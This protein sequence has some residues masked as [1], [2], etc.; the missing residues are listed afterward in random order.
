MSSNLEQELLHDLEWETT[1]L[2][3]LVREYKDDQQ[4]LKNNIPEYV[5]SILAI[6]AV[7]CGVVYTTSAEEIVLRAEK[8]VKDLADKYKFDASELISGSETI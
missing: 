3:T 5:G 4:T 2:R 6:T 1:Q 7:L 8:Y